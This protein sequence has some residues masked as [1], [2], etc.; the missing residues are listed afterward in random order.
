[1]KPGALSVVR[2]G[3]IRDGE[4]RFVMIVS[5]RLG[6]TEAGLREALRTSVNSGAT[7]R[8]RSVVAL[9]GSSEQVKILVLNC[10]EIKKTSNI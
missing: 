5:L 1:M 4:T 2:G 3:V 10:A 9:M 6:G 8:K 7:T